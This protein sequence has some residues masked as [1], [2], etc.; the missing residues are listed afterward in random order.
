[1]PAITIAVRIIAP[2]ASPDANE[3]VFLKGDLT[4]TF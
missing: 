2:S 4:T 3:S 1:V